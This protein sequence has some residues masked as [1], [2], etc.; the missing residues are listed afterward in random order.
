MEDPIF[1]LK[2]EIEELKAVETVTKTNN[3]VPGKG[4][5]RIREILDC[6]N[7]PPKN[8]KIYKE[9]NGKITM[10]VNVT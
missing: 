8:G 7:T 6:M 4:I 1:A 10:G 9:S 3:I 5:R 2:D